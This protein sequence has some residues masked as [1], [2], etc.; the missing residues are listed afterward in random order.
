MK[1][2]VKLQGRDYHC[3]ELNTGHIFVRIN[4]LIFGVRHVDH[5]DIGIGYINRQALLDPSQVTP[6]RARPVHLTSVTI[7]AHS[8][9]N[10][11]FTEDIFRNHVVNANVIGVIPTHVMYRANKTGLI[12]DRT[13]I[14]LT[15]TSDTWDEICSLIQTVNTTWEPIP[16]ISTNWN[17]EDLGIGGLNEQLREIFVK[18]FA[19]RL[20]PKKFNV[21]HNKG[22]LLYGPPGTGKT[23]IAR[24]IGE[25]FGCKEVEVIAGPALMNKWVGGSAE[26]VRKLF[27][28]P[29]EKGLKLIIIDE[30]EVVCQKRRENSHESTVVNQLLA[31][32]D[33][34]DT[35]DNFIIVGMT[36]RRDMIDAALLRPGRFGLQIEIPLPDLEGRKSIL[37]IHAKKHNLESIFDGVEEETQGWSGAELA[38]LVE[39]SL[40]LAFTQDLDLTDDNWKDKLQGAEVTRVHVDEAMRAIKERKKR[41][42]PYDEELDYRAF[43]HLGKSELFRIQTLK[44]IISKAGPVVKVRSLLRPSILEEI[45]L[46]YSDKVIQFL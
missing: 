43:D 38:S 21:R 10:K 32:M 5:S 18:G 4:G 27:P 29:S 34:V 42:N 12:T 33:G 16:E 46:Y 23:L 1:T 19:S 36:N 39:D 37:E 26:N 17:L 35:V 15:S 22:V 7:D 2:V 44:E 14:T 3:V 24:K 11:A 31:C 25:V 20:L 30:L 6:M 28:D 8:I 9:S 41:K 45:Q 40:A 13:K